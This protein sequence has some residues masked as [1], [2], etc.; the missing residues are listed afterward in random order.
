MQEY[1][2]QLKTEEDLNQILF[3]F[4]WSNDPI[5]QLSRKKLISEYKEGGIKMIDITSKLETCYVEKIK[6]LCNIEKVTEL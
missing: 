6:Y 5:E 3:K 4:L 1:I 2:N